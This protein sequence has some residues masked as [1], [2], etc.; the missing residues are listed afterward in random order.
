MMLWYIIELVVGLG[1]AILVHEFGHFLAARWAGIK[2][3][4]FSI[5]FPP[6]LA[7]FKR[8]QTE[9]VIGA[10]PLGGYVKLAGEE[11]GETGRLKKDDLMAQPFWIRMIVYASGVVMNG[12]MAYLIFFGLLVYG[13]SSPQF[14]AKVV[15]TA[16]TGAAA[17]AGFQTGD[18]ITAVAG[19]PV[20]SWEEAM[21]LAYG[22][23]KGKKVAMEVQR[24]GEKVDVRLAFG[25]DPGMEPLME[26]VIGTVE[27][28]QPGRKAGLKPDD[29]ILSING[30][31]VSRWGEISKLVSGTREG[32]AIRV[33]V[34]RG[35]KEMDIRV[36]PRYDQALKR[37]LI[38]ISV[39]P[40]WMKKE[41]F[42]PGEAAAVSGKTMWMFS[43]QIVL[44]VWKA[45]SGQAKFKDVLGGPVMIARVGYEKARQGASDLLHFIAVLSISL[46]VV[47]LLP[48]PAVDGGMIFLAFLE[49]IR[50]RRFSANTYQNLTTAGFAFLI[51]VFLFATYNDILR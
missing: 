7:G 40:S 50:G 35:E 32:K 37:S 31:Q 34:R 15:V 14:P 6:R 11:W 5:G 9:Y 25:S 41:K 43:S 42:G 1:L 29:R 16:E 46:L 4:K 26:P 51:A 13:I 23:G 10:V 44:S 21:E 45:V 2:V 8:G 18:V 22:A 24:G 17:R 48:I 38:G 19:K 36:V 49:G 39:K 47:N 27:P 3:L 28:F 33:T 20:K 30:R 12:I